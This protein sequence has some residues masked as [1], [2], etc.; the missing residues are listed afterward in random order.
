MWLRRIEDVQRREM[1]LIEHP[2][3]AKGHVERNFHLTTSA[4]MGLDRIVNRLCNGM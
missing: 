4:V 1:L 3:F 2:R